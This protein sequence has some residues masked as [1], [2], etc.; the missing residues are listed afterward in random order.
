[1]NDIIIILT[2]L[3]VP[4]G[5]FSLIGSVHSGH[6][7]AFFL[8]GCAIFAIRIENF[9]LKLFFLYIIFYQ[10]CVLVSAAFSEI[11]RAPAGNM[12]LFYILLS[13]MIFTYV[14]SSNIPFRFFYNAICISALIQATIGIFQW[15]G[16]DL[17]YLCLKPIIPFWVKLKPLDVPVGTLANENYLAAYLAISLPFFFRKRW[18]FAIPVISASLLMSNTTTAMFS[19]FVAVSVFFKYTWVIILSIFGFIIYA[20]FID[21]DPSAIFAND[22][23]VIWSTALDKIFTNFKT[24]IFGLGPGAGYGQPYALHNEY[25]TLWFHFGIIALFLISGFIINVERSNKIL[26]S[27]FGAIV[28]NCLG[29]LP[30]QLAP[31]LFLILIVIGLLERNKLHA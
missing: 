7:L 2:F 11:P 24:I 12:L 1:M 30:M 19:A 4:F 23:F 21:S 16:F 8:S 9:W 15:L 26:I 13:L 6:L 17:V 29:N 25:L 3:M 18:I 28:S 14:K 31:S 5:Y 10:A 22:R 27:S 20:A